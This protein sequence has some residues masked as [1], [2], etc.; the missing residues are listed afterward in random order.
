M[1][2][3]YNITNKRPG[4]S[5]RDRLE[6][7]KT[8]RAEYSKLEPIMTE[9][10]RILIAKSINEKQSE[11][12]SYIMQGALSE[13]HYAI[14][15]Y[16]NAVKGIQEA[17]NREVSRWEAI[18][19]NAEID[20]AERLVTKAVQSSTGGR[21]DPSVMPRLKA[22]YD[23]AQNSGDIYKMRAMAEVFTGLPSM[24]GGDLDDRMYAN[25]LSQQA[26]RD[27]QAV[28]VT[29]EI[30]KAD[31]LARDAVETLTQAKSALHEVDEGF[32]QTRPN[33]EVG[34]WDIYKELNRVRTNQRG[35]VVDIVPL[36]DALK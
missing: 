13:W 2:M 32:G 7:L 20:T 10:E 27:A 15:Q 5:W 18:K 3:F 29:R 30:E 6:E 8:A 12:G 31:Q 4:A 23:E 22:M 19:L 33:G 14:D 17:K 35:E 26:Q 16:K 24:V 34:N 11:V 9:V 1:S 28:R 36:E 21:L 25:K